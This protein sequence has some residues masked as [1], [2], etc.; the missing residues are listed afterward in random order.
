MP[1][2]VRSF[3]GFTLFLRS[4]YSVISIVRLNKFQTMRRLPGLSSCL[5]LPFRGF[6]C[7]K[8][9]CFDG[10]FPKRIKAQVRAKARNNYVWQGTGK[11]IERNPARSFQSGWFHREEGQQRLL[12]GGQWK[13]L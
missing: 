3:A 1:P 8:G 9:T 13:R 12:A 11:W 5:Q 6:G 10:F 7:G 2:D 4:R